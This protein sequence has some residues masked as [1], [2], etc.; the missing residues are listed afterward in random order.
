[1]PI[2]RATQSAASPASP[3]SGQRSWSSATRVLFRFGFIYLVLYSLIP[4]TLLSTTLLHRPWLS[5]ESRKLWTALSALAAMHIFQVSRFDRTFFASDS[6]LGWSL[7]GSFVAVSAAATILWSAADR[8]RQE[9]SRLHAW[10]RVIVQAVLALTLVDYGAQKIWPNQM[11]VPRLHQL[12]SELGSYSP[13]QLFWVF[14]GASPGYERFAG[15]IELLAGGLLFVPALTTLGALLA[16]IATAQVFAFNVY[17]DVQVKVFSFHL[18]LMAAFLLVPDIRRLA[19]A[20]IFARATAPSQRPPLFASR[21]LAQ[22]ASLGSLLVGA[23]VIVNA[24]WFC[25][26]NTRFFNPDPSAIP[27]YGIW[28]VEDFSMDG[29]SRP[30]LLTDEVRWQK[31][32]FDDLNSAYIQRMNGAVI[33]TRLQRDASRGVMTITSLGDPRP[34]MQDFAGSK[35]KAE[36]NTQIISPDVILLSGKYNRSSVTVKL[37]RSQIRFLLRPHET[38]WVLHERGDFN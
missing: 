2:A 5:I 38:H 36:L 22:A 26:A 24:L 3:T 14:V 27:S 7:V 32:V 23:A 13:G 15:F 12:L 34:E 4:L 10:L 11:P 18:F 33:R 29:S 30:P 19:D 28:D 21:R 16:F 1:M 25:H 35:W 31:I 9:Y 20:L 17:Y 37:R 6:V 8:R